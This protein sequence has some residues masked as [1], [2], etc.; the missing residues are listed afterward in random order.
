MHLCRF[1]RKNITV[2]HERLFQGGNN[3]LCTVTCTTNTETKVQYELCPFMSKMGL[4]AF[5]IFA[6]DLVSFNIVSISPRGQ[7]V[8]DRVQRP[9]QDDDIE[10]DY[11]E[12]PTDYTENNMF[13]RLISFAV[14]AEQLSVYRVKHAHNYL[15]SV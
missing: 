7:A 13:R 15:C 8:R 12:V 1:S 3:L 14:T 5:P 4:F 10:G 6:G 9:D 2:V 11:N